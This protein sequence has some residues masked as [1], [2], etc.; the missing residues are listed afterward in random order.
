M[1]RGEIKY[2]ERWEERDFAISRSHSERLQIR[3]TTQ[4]T[5]GLK[6]KQSME[7]G[8]DFL[9]YD[10]NKAGYESEPGWI[11]WHD[12]NNHRTPE[13]YQMSFL[14]HASLLFLMYKR[15]RMK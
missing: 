3:H 13:D 11:A 8:K 2:E 7:P 6:R 4:I 14:F 9:Y 10:W 1:K 12:K 15:N 5:G